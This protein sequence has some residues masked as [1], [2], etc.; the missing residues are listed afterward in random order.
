MIYACKECGRTSQ[1]W[2]ECHEVPD[3]LMCDVCLIK[4]GYKTRDNLMMKEGWVYAPAVRT[5]DGTGFYA[6]TAVPDD[7]YQHWL[8]EVESR[9]DQQLRQLQ[10]GADARRFREVLKLLVAEH[11]ICVVQLPRG[12]GVNAKDGAIHVEFATFAQAFEFALSLLEVKHE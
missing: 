6:Y 7:A 1:L 5:P 11:N 12:W 4:L 9:I 2:R 10:M 8:G 3:I